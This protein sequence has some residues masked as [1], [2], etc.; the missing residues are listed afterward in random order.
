[1][2]LNVGWHVTADEAVQTDVA[3]AAE[4]SGFRFNLASESLAYVYYWFTKPPNWMLLLP[5]AALIR[6]Q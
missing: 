3:M 5:H 1:M 2:L 4:L 6:L